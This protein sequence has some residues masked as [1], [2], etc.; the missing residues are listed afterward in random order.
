ML[1]VV[2]FKILGPKIA[3]RG[4][5]LKDSMAVILS[6]YE[7][8]QA[9]Y[10]PKMTFPVGKYLHALVSGQSITVD[11]TVL[12]Y[13]RKSTFTNSITSFYVANDVTDG[14][15]IVPESSL[16]LLAR[17]KIRNSSN[18]YEKEIKE[19]FDAVWDDLK[20]HILS[21]KSGTACSKIFYLECCACGCCLR[22]SKR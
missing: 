7:N 5:G 12:E 3:D 21:K 8:P 9:R 20:T 4:K 11:N 15:S 18:E 2:N 19:E 6:T 1:S 13:V 17:A 16:S 22:S 10:Y 14:D